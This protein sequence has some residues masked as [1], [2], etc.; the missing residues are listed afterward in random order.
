LLTAITSTYCGVHD[1]NLL[2]SVR[3]C[4]HIHLMSKTPA[5]KTAAKAALTQIISIVCQRM[6]LSEAQ[7]NEGIYE[8]DVVSTHRVNVDHIDPV[9]ASE[10]SEDSVKASDEVDNAGVDFPSAF[11]KDA[12]L[13]FRALC[14]LSMK[15]VA[16]DQVAYSDNLVVQNKYVSRPTIHV[17]YM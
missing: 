14:K 4:F 10:G 11:H 1:A 16:D 17:Q 13:L 8:E 9:T 5:I 12:Y 2:L 6:E 15:G 7:Q 3:A